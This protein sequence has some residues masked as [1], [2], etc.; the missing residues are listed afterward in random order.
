MTETGEL[1]GGGLVAKALKNEGVEHIFSLSGGH[2]N[3]VFDGCVTENINIV[4][5]HHEQAAVHMAE[6]WARYTG[7][8]GVAVV[9]A[10]PGVVNALPGMAVASQS[11]VPLVLIGGRSSLARRDI[12][13]MQDIDQLELMRP[14]TKWARQVYQAERIPEYI[15]TA[16]RQ[17][18]SG[19]PGP[20]FL[21]I[22]VDIM[23]Q[24]TC[25]EQVRFPSSYYCTSRPCAEEKD[26]KKAAEMLAAAER[27]VI[28]AGSGVFWSGAAAELEG[29]AESAGIPVY[30]RNMGRGTFPEDH[31]LAGGFFP[32]GLMQADLILILG[33]RL[34]W[35]AGYGRPP[36]MKMGTKTIHVDIEPSELGQNRPVDLGLVG[37]IK[38]IL[39][40]LQGVLESR[41]MQLESS[42]P[43]N[44][45]AMREAARE[46]AVQNADPESEY[47]HPAL[48]CRELK[49][50][51][52]PGTS[53][54]IDG[55]D[56]AGFAVLTMD[57]LSPSSLIWIGAFGHLGVGLPFAVAGKLASPERPLVLLTGDGSFG[58]SAM[59]FATAVRHKLPVICVIANDAGWGQ[60]RR[61]QLRDYDR[62][63][64][65][66]LNS[67]RFDRVAEDLGGFG[68]YVESLDELKPAFNKAL[69]SGLP[70]CI[71]VR[72]DPESGFAGMDLPWK[73][74]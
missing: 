2:I 22:P 38:A 29:F 61:G 42:W 3:A 37:D 65:V 68:A 15:A 24:K 9:T 48:L 53:L 47:I 19:R 27:P 39:K 4:D 49:S 30:T 23:N 44:I 57:A 73:I 31:E 67:L 16:F 34:D 59:E 13:A 17:A 10:G 64:G 45:K 56:I 50:I 43:G 25:V 32:I 6:G 11:G 20:V 33:T 55:G 12:G 21:E 14:L 41:K 28:L 35:T 5:A 36:L 74:N 18:V 1:T 46:N 40:Q 70:A 72:T 71:N 58:F 7:R 63:V 52:P 8:P 69:K 26:I 62:T 60:I 66:E 51:L 54:V